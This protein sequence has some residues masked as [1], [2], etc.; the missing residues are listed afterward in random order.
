MGRSPHVGAGV[1]KGRFEDQWKERPV[2]IGASPATPVR[3]EESVVTAVEIDVDGG[4]DA[5]ALS[6]LLVPFRSFL[7]EH[8]NERWVVPARAPG[9]HGEPL[10]DA[11]L[12]IE[13][14][15][16]ERGRH[17]SVRVAGRPHGSRR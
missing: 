15:R 11:L 6:E 12:A 4:W 17:V 2:S 3:A 8:T 7:V 13:E 1:L 5:L 9:C 14:W 10:A 16:S